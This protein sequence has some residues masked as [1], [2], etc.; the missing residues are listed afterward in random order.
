MAVAR[1]GFISLDCADPVKLA[2]FWAAMPGGEI[3]FTTATTVD[4]ARTGCG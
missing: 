2:E 1:S 3:M 4:I